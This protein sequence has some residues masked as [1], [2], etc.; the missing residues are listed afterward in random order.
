MDNKCKGC[1]SQDD[2]LV[3]EFVTKCPC[4]ECI[5]K[6]SCSSLCQDYISFLSTSISAMKGIYPNMPKCS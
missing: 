5:V 6:V 2:C 1:Q 4:K 3:V